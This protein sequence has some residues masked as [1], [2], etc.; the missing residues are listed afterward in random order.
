LA[1]LATGK[2]VQK[3]APTTDCSQFSIGNMPGPP[4]SQVQAGALS[5][6]YAVN[7]PLQI[8]DQNDPTK[9]LD[10]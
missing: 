8:T 5:T 4:G 9:H 7:G 3:D 6:S 1:D 2:H 10:C